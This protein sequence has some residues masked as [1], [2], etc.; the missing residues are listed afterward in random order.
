LWT[1]CDGRIAGTLVGSRRGIR[2]E[3]MTTDEAT[4]LLKTARNEKASGDDL[5]AA[6]T[7]FAM[8]CDTTF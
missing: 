2:V 7:L 6:G 3:L 8:F 4:T 5:Q 1:S